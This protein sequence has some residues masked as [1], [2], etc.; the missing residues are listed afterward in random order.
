LPTHC[1]R[2][3]ALTLSVLSQKVGC[4]PVNKTCSATTE[5]NFPAGCNNADGSCILVNITNL[6]D[7]C[8]V[9]L[10]DDASCF[11]SSVY[12]VSNI[13]GIAG[14]ESPPSCDAS[15]LLLNSLLV[16]RCGCRYRCGLHPCSCSVLL[17]HQE[18]YVGQIVS[19]VWLTPGAPTPQATITT[20][21][22]AI[23]PRK[24]STT[25]QRS[26]YGKLQ[27]YS[28]GSQFALQDN[29]MSGQMAGD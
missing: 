27:H 6:I 21:R 15:H 1:L 5:C 22:R 24:V 7:F 23:C 25:T 19:F 28:I 11:F 20:R 12:P 17:A 9:C 13:G 14:G 8:G 3:F 18:G 2:C 10:G 16:T 29:V 4:V 26:R